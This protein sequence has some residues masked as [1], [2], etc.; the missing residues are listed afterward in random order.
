MEK[1]ENTHF[2]SLWLIC[3]HSNSLVTMVINGY[4][5]Q[6][7]N[8]EILSQHNSQFFSYESVTIN[9]DDYRSLLPI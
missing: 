4:S 1:N 7:F 8:N 6:N 5:I 9:F 2:F 3:C